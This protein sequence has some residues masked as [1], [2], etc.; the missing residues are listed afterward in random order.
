MR[1]TQTHEP[2]PTQMKPNE[3]SPPRPVFGHQR[4]VGHSARFNDTVADAS[5]ACN[6][7]VRVPSN[8]FTASSIF[9][10]SARVWATGTTL[11]CECADTSLVESKTPNCE[12]SLHIVWSQQQQLTCVCT[13]LSCMGIFNLASFLLFS[14]QPAVPLLLDCGLWCFWVCLHG[15]TLYHYVPNMSCPISLCWVWFLALALAWC[16][17]STRFPYIHIYKT[18]FTACMASSG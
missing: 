13:N 11:W 18:V 14:R 2:M 8:S 4:S 7:T 9:D 12:F 17:I 10:F 6:N 16:W 3:P 1:S 15:G 5:I